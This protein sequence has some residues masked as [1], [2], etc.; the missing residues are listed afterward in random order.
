MQSYE[1]GLN[2]CVV[3]NRAA[4]GISEKLW[5]SIIAY[6]LFHYHQPEAGEI[7]IEAETGDIVKN[8]LYD[9][10]GNGVAKGKSFALTQKPENSFSF[11]ANRLVVLNDLQG[12]FDFIQKT[13]GCFGMKP[14]K[15]ESSRFTDSASIIFL[16]PDD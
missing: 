15:K 7:L 3:V 16:G 8:G 4:V 9:H 14:V 13:D 10:I 1:N 11:L 5:L 6:H 12:R 2:S